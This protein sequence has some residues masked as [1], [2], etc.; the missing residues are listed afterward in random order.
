MITADTEEY[1]A[2]ICQS[3]KGLTLWLCGYEEVSLRLAI[4]FDYDARL[5][6]FQPWSEIMQ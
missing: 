4:K 3:G 2:E 5:N 6:V 1:G